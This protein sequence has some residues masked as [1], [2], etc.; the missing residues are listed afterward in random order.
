MAKM[1]AECGL[2]GW[3]VIDKPRGVTSSRVVERVRR[4]TGAKA[5]HAGTL[6]PLATGVLPIALGEATKT[7]AYAMGGRKTYRFCVRWGVACDSDDADGEIVG[8]SPVRPDPAAIAAVLPRFTGLIEQV[9]PTYSAI[10]IGGRRA[11]ALARAGRACA[12]GPR[13]VEISTLRLVATPDGDHAEFEAV[14]GKGA[15]VR[16]LARDMALALGTFGHVTA[17]RRLAVGRFTE[18]DAVALEFSADE[19]HIRLASQVLLPLETALDGMPELIVS[20]NDA[21]RLRCGQRV[22]QSAPGVAPGSIVGV[23]HANALVAFAKL[24]DGNLR[25]LRVINR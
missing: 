25:A 11:Y 12:L 23:W 1:T 2:S 19:R 15:Y 21:R 13:P 3:L 6:D 4:A 9:P 7:V 8:D 16:A 5:G 17:L 24:E 20:A 22:E 14:V 10:K 18:A